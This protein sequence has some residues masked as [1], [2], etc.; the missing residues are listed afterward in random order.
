MRYKSQ[1]P[2][3]HRGITEI[4]YCVSFIDSGDTVSFVCMNPAKIQ[5]W[6]LPHFSF[7]Y[8]RASPLHCLHQIRKCQLTIMLISITALFLE[9]KF[10]KF[11]STFDK[12]SSIWKPRLVFRIVPDFLLASCQ[13]RYL[14]GQGVISASLSVSVS[15]HRCRIIHFMPEKE[16]RI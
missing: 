15:C 1:C 2:K 12:F 8:K 16:M 4:G 5:I 14:K 6:C 7:Y 13:S 11:S 9:F 3:Q 10:S